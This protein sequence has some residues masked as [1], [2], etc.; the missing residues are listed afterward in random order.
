MKPKK[1]FEYFTD[2]TKLAVMENTEQAKQQEVE[3]LQLM[4][5]NQQLRQ[6]LNIHYENQKPEVIQEGLEELK[7]RDELTLEL[8]NQEKMADPERAEELDQMI[9]NEMNNQL[10][11]HEADI[12]RTQEDYLILIR[13]E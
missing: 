10:N 4:E 7:E 11:F 9:E 5:E 3:I 1:K 6:L 8:L 2:I 13:E 12:Q